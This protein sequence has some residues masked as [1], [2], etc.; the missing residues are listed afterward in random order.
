MAVIVTV[1]ISMLARVT[2]YSVNQLRILLGRGDFSK[3]RNNRGILEGV[4]KEH[5]ALLRF[6]KKNREEGKGFYGETRTK[7]F[8]YRAIKSIQIPSNWRNPIITKK[9]KK[10]R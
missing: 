2:G 9:N 1:H 10:H 3:I 8:N 7:W 4:T 6:M 5:V